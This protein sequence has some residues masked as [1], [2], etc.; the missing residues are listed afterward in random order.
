MADCDQDI[1]AFLKG[2]GKGHGPFFAIFPDWTPQDY[3]VVCS[4]IENAC[5]EVGISLRGH[6][7]RFSVRNGRVANITGYRQ[8]IAVENLLFGRYNHDDLFSMP[9]QKDPSIPRP[10]WFQDY[11]LAPGPH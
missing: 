10:S 8:R 4:R 6:L 9:Y 3:E 1:D 5:T 7:P 11:M 2:D